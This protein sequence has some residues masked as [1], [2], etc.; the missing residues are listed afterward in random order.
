MYMCTLFMCGFR[1][2]DVHFTLSEYYRNLVWP[3]ALEDEVC[4]V[5]CAS[6]AAPGP[7]SPRHHQATLQKKPTLKLRLNSVAMSSRLPAARSDGSALSNPCVAPSFEA[8]AVWYAVP[9]R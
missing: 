9:F 6:S 8:D 5:I 7:A 4:N 3:T 2:I 1:R